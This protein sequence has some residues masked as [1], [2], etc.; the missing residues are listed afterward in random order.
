MVF[1][2]VH[3]YV[4]IYIYMMLIVALLI[5][6]EGRSETAGEEKYLACSLSYVEFD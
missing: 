6:I 2:T 4:Y 3:I 5:G 1:G